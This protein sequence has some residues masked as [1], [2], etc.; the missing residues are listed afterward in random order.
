MPQYQITHQTSY[1]FDEPVSGLEIYA[2]LSPRDV[3]GQIS[4]C[5]HVIS[6]PMPVRQNQDIDSFGNIRTHLFYAKALQRIDITAVST[7]AVANPVQGNDNKLNGPKW[8][9]LYSQE[10]LDKTASLVA[11]YASECIEGIATT[12]E[13]VNAVMQKIYRDYVYDL[14]ATSVST[15][16]NEVLIKKRGVC[17]DFARA[18]IAI[19]QL[20]HIPAC[21]VSGYLFCGENARGTARQAASHAWV[22]VYIP[23]QGWVGV[24]PTNNQW[25]N[26]DYVVLAWGRDYADIIPVEGLLK[27]DHSQRLNVSVTIE[28]L[29]H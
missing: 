5:H 26:E 2:C 20:N 22:M 1:H 19:L 29:N 23:Q 13:Q 17:Q 21:Y 18:M 14:N 12:V 24:D 3:D 16:L 6:V 28:K 8:H 9:E 10:E 27:K 4:E 15:S 25:V 11:D 7:V